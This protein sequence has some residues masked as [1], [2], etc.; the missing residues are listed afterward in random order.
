[1]TRGQASPG[2]GRAA[3]SSE[4]REH[5][6]FR[7]GRD[8]PLLVAALAL[9]SMGDFLAIVAL[10]IRIHDSSGSGWAV[11][12]L[13][14]AGLLPLIVFAPVGGLLVDR[15]E[16]TRVLVFASLIQA[17]VAVALAYVESIPGILA[18]V[19]LLN[20]GLAVTQPGFFALVPRVAGEDRVTEA[21]AFLELARYGG[22][23]FGPVLAGG[24][25]AGVGVRYALLGDS[26]TFVVVA[27]CCL[28]LTVRLPA[29]RTHD[30]QG[31]LQSELAREG[32][33]FILRDR[34]LR[35]VLGV[36]AISVLFAATSNVAAVFFA[37]DVLHAGNTGFG[38]M[39]AAWAGGMAIVAIAVARGRKPSSLV[40]AALASAVI[41]GGSLVVT[42]L[43][44]LLPVAVALYLV[45]GGANG[46]ENI[47]MRS[48]I[49]A[50]TPEQMRGRVYAAYSALGT[51]AQ[52]ASM[53]LGGL[54]VTL[55]GARSTL[56]VAGTCGLAVGALG[57]ALFSRTQVGEAAG[58]EG[59]KTG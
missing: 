19:F 2:P 49:H 8:L 18:L 40:V 38:L 3:A 37:K 35:L 33:R 54:M 53:G 15:Y 9:S 17:V 10:T 20:M 58:P 47:A 11:S 41:M 45:G 59:L 24:L 14:L 46:M 5:T 43:F 51:G 56:L 23:T 50:R 44:A 25:A 55:L 7:R 48:L 29:T 21:N 13:L 27:V 34:L 1:M 6:R 31:R 30:E 39:E 42:G 12:A 28:A 36:M 26:L 52:V 57:L 22:A 32:A 16:T 4:G